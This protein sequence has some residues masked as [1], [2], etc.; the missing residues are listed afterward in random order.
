MKRII[1][2]RKRIT[3]EIL[4]KK[5]GKNS[6]IR[7]GVGYGFISDEY[8]YDNC[9]LEVGFGR[10]FSGSGDW[11]GGL[12]R[13]SDSPLKITIDKN[14]IVQK[15]ETS[16]FYNNSKSREVERLVIELSKRIKVGKKFIV[17]NDTLKEHLNKLLDFIPCKYTIGHDVFNYPHML[18][19]YTNPTN[20]NYYTFREPKYNE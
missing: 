16:S 12:D 19:H 10:V 18:S 20:K 2:F 14:Y 7:N 1:I 5:L 4:F 11:G 6:Y 13:I 15:V 3:D 8:L 9:F 17:K